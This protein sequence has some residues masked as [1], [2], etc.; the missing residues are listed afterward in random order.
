MAGYLGCCGDA[1]AVAED[2]AL[3][4][5]VDMEAIGPATFVPLLAAPLLT[6]LALKNTPVTRFES[7]L[8]LALAALASAEAAIKILRRWQA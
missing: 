5:V 7:K 4:A 6:Y 3:S 2:V 1:A 8:M